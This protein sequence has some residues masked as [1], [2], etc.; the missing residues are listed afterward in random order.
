MNEL[1]IKQA[2]SETRLATFEAATR[3]EPVLS[4]ALALYAWN[5]QVAAA[6]LA[7]LHVCEVVLRNAVSDA[8][9]AVYGHRWPWSPGFEKSLPDSAKGYSP[10]RDLIQARESRVNQGKVIAEL[11]FFFWQ[12]MFT[13]RFDARLWGPH[14]R[15]VMPAMDASREVASL[16]RLIFDELEQVR[17]L[18]NRI[19]HH[20]PV[21]KRDLGADFQRICKLI[22]WRSPETA[23][24]LMQN[25]KVLTL[26]AERP[27]IHHQGRA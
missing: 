3:V 11:P 15:H 13:Q 17:K 12:T 23:T 19:A 5:A 20:E 24:W 22:A 7:P 27:P 8:I 21:F 1:A 16:R 26:L 25:Q 18:R 10:R 6:M 9:E 14:L 4:N 2:L